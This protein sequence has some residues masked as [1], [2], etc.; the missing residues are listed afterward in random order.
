MVSFFKKSPPKPVPLPTL[1]TLPKKSKMNDLFEPGAK[2]YLNPA[3]MKIPDDDLNRRIEQAEHNVTIAGKNNKKYN[4]AETKSIYD[5]AVK[6]YSDLM[7][8]Y[9]EKKS[10]KNLRE[11]LKDEKQ[12]NEWLKQQEKFKKDVMDPLEL[13]TKEIQRR[14]DEVSKLL[15]QAFREDQERL[16][17]SEKERQAHQAEMMRILG[18]NGGRKSRKRSNKKLKRKTRKH[19]K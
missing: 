16:E 3:V 4:T 11:R 1:A 2:E 17:K 12:W 7:D 8:I 9:T 14:N 18:I 19:R 13:Y 10:I 5:K 6:V 15:A